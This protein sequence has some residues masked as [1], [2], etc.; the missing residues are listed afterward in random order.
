MDTVSRLTIT[1]VMS[2]LLTENVTATY[3]RR[4]TAVHVDC[5]T[6]SWIPVHATTT[7]QTAPSHCFSLVMASATKTRLQSERQPS[8]ALYPGNLTT[9]K[10]Q[11][12]VIFLSDRV[13]RHTTSPA[14]A[15]LIEQQSTLL[16]R[17]TTSADITPTADAI[18]TQAAVPTDFIRSAVSAIVNPTIP[19]SDTPSQRV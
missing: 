13:R 7:R 3:P 5:L 15:T 19:T 12:N 8:A 6:V 17:A 2:F 10:G 9:M 4:M 1:A 16:A 18:I 11:M 14:N